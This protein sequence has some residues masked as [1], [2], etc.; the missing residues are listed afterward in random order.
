MITPNSQS[1]SA[2]SAQLW[3]TWSVRPP[4]SP[5]VMYLMHWKPGTP[6]CC[7]CMCS[8]GRLEHSPP[9]HRT[10]WHRACHQVT[11]D[12]SLQA[13]THDVLRRVEHG[14]VHVAVEHEGNVQ[15]RHVIKVRREDTVVSVARDVG[16]HL[17]V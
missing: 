16:K 6:R 3:F 5:R 4:C 10:P 12:C 9:N 11:A 8:H 17:L 1:H 13:H 2:K 7:C 15:P 14:V